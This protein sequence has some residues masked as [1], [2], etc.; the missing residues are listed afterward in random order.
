MIS[1]NN[2]NITQKGYIYIW[3]SN[4]SDANLDVFFDDLKVTHTKGHI[5]QEDHYYPF[6]M[7]INALSSSA[8][9]SKPNRF[10]YNG[11]EIQSDFDLD[12]YDYGAR[13]YN[14][15]IG[16]WN[17]VDPLAD[18]YLPFS[19]YNYT[20]NNPL[21]FIDPDGRSVKSTN[22]SVSLDGEDA[23]ELWSNILKYTNGCPTGD[24]DV[25]DDMTYHIITDDDG[26]E[27]AKIPLGPFNNRN[28][29]AS[30]AFG[31]NMELVWT[32]IKGMVIEVALYYS[33][34]KVLS[35]VAKNGK[36]FIRWIAPKT[37]ELMTRTRALLDAVKLMNNTYLNNGKAVLGHF[38]KTGMGYIEKAKS[39]SASY[40][41]LG[42]TWRLLPESWRWNLNRIFLDR[43]IRNGDDVYLSVSKQNIRQNSVLVDEIKYLQENGYKWVNQWV[44][45]KVK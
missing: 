20:L 40:F 27:L 13:I 37:K 2:I 41:D 25:D 21:R 32:M 42:D 45:K 33:G 24:C 28:F 7:N 34:G 35:V 26:N 5:L 44:L 23:E 3:V 18:A 31:K 36:W 22:H 29:D 43:V 4:E 19:P 1:L 38:S 8:V 14:P 11:K 6:G 12:W 10:K 17:A 39:M 16:R 15:T 9:L 30:A